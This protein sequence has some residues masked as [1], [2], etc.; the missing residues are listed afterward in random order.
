MS[1]PA[2]RFPVSLPE[3]GAEGR[4]LV[5][6][7]VVRGA[8]AHLICPL[9]ATRVVAVDSL[10]VTIGGRVGRLVEDR[11]RSSFEAV[12]VVS[13]ALP[14]PAPPGPVEV[15][16]EWSGARG[17][18]WTEAEAGTARGGLAVVTLFRDDLEE[19]EAFVGYYKAIGFERFHL[20][21]NGSLQSVRHRL[22]TLEGVTYGEWNFPYLEGDKAPADGRS[23][24]ATCARRLADVLFGFRKAF[25]HHAQPPFLEMARLRVLPDHDWVFFCDLDEYLWSERA[26]ASLLDEVGTTHVSIESHWATLRRPSGGL[27]FRSPQRLAEL[28]GKIR[29]AFVSSFSERRP[30]VR[31]AGRTTL[32]VNGSGEGLKR[33]KTLYAKSHGGP[34]GVHRP[35]DAGVLHVVEGLELA[36]IVDVMHPERR[37]LIDAR[38]CIA[39]S[40]DG[41]S[42]FSK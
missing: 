4:W 31:F 33:M 15:L 38:D 25:K 36:H 42:G 2:A 34:V 37:G 19:V 35:L 30:V 21:F 26:L 13:L 9:Y 3:P 7:V 24:I 1:V 22:P 23:R 28:V 14:E 12:R 17:G 11:R 18:G 39:L 40:S 29:K 27:R 41:R 16:V 10:H 5:F 6:D 32:W 20:Y 8:C